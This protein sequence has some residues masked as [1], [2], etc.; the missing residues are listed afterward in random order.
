MARMRS[1]E[2]SRSPKP[3]CRR[4]KSGHSRVAMVSHEARRKRARPHSSSSWRET[5]GSPT[6]LACRVG[7]RVRVRVGVKLG[8]KVGVKHG[9]AHLG[10]RGRGR[11]GAALDQDDEL[12][13]AI[14]AQLTPPAHLTPPAQLGLGLR[15]RGAPLRVAR[16]A[17]GLRRRAWPRR[18]AAQVRGREV[19]PVEGELH[20]PEHAEEGAHRKR[21]AEAKQPLGQ[22]AQ[23][24][25]RVPRHVER[26]TARAQHGA[27]H[28]EGREEERPPSGWRLRRHVRR[29][30]T[31][32]VTAA[33]AG[34]RRRGHEPPEVLRKASEAAAD[35]ARGGADHD[36]VQRT[37]AVLDP[38]VERSRQYEA[39]ERDG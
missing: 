36:G 30:R 18:G 25:P 38:T 7:V 19:P 37:V 5:R 27:L 9:G 1:A 29:D 2:Y 20:H 13:R 8:V 39:H 16:V 14:A 34:E 35:R 23:P 28:G 4:R 11:R 17:L 15:A 3:K 12:R 24:Q 10:G 32:E 21:D 33:E 22:P 6:G 31:H 26:L